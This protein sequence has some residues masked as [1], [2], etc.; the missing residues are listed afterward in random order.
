M[1]RPGPG[2][3]SSM[4]WT[5]GPGPGT[6]GGWDMQEQKKPVVAMK[7]IVKEF[8]GVRCKTVLCTLIDDIQRL[9]KFH[10]TV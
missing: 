3:S 4:G 10:S 7:G 1:S 2:Q 6:D 8:P 5:A 9:C